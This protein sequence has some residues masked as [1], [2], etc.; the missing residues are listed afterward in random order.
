MKLSGVVGVLALGAC[1]DNASGPVPAIAEAELGCREVP[2]TDLAAQFDASS[3]LGAVVPYTLEGED[4]TGRWFVTD[5][6]F[7]RSSVVIA[8]APTGFVVDGFEVTTSSSEMFGTAFAA[9]SHEGSEPY[10]FA[11][12]VSNLRED[13]SL[14]YDNAYCDEDTCTVCTARLIRAEPFDPQ[15]SEKLSLLG[16]ISGPDWKGVTLDVG[17]AGTTAFVIRDTGLHAIDVAD[18]TRP[19]LLGSAPNLDPKTRSNDLAL[20]EAAGRRYALIA[21]SPVQLVDVTDPND[22]QPAGMIPVEAHTL[23]IETRN[24]QTLAYFGSLD[25]TCPVYDLTDPAHPARLGAFDAHASY[26]HD[27]SVNDGIAYL[28]AWEKGFFVVDYRDP[29]QPVELGHWDAPGRTSHHNWTTLA[30]DGRRIAMHGEETYGA[31]MTIIDVEPTS[32]QFMQPLGEYETREYVSIHNFTGVGTKAYMAYY[33]DG[34]RVVDVADPARPKQLG[35]FNTWDPH[36]V[37]ASNVFYTGAIGIALD[38]AREL[39]FVADTERGL[40]ILR[41]D[42]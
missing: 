13:G 36:D 29:A 25:G 40:L 18:P 11:V 22:L 39:V 37:G 33:Q 41:D 17:V 7:Y 3:E 5:T 21:A 20:F 23:V 26:V 34:V 24:A 14:R 8:R 35:Y 32:P 10:R 1:G 2:S 27:L 31:H 38:V 28:N 12:R 4:L 6:F 9:V 30:A 15:P 19:R 42:T 16:E